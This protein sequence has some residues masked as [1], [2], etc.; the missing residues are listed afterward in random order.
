MCF[1]FVLLG[2]FIYVFSQATTNQT[3]KVHVALVDHDQTFETQTLAN[4]LQNEEALQDAIEITPYS[5][6]KANK[7]FQSNQVVALIEIPEGFTSDLRSGVNTP[8]TV[9]TNEDNPLSANMVKLLLDSGAQ[10]ISAAQSAINTVYD[11]YIQDL[12]E[13]DNPNELLQQFIVQYTLFALDRN[14]LFETEMIE[15]GSAL[16]W[17]QHGMIA[18]ILTSCMLSAIFFQMF[19]QKDEDQG[20]RHRLRTFHCTSFTWFWS[21]FLLYVILLFL[22]LVSIS[23]LLYGLMKMDWLLEFKTFGTWLAISLLFAII[24]S[25]LDWFIAN[26]TSRT[27]LFIIVISLLYFMSGIWLPL[28][29]LPAWVE[30]LS[31][32]SP[33]YQIYEGIEISI[34]SEEIPFQNWIT[35]GF[36][37]GIL[38]LFTLFKVW[39]K[40]RK[41][42]YLS[43]T[44]S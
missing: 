19:T 27:G 25:L 11:L 42:G 4:Q 18:F 13:Q 28:V 16:G 23:L 44:S 41:D 43:L 36:M 24:L 22:N 39:R 5:E 7:A 20:I 14:E 40:E 34:L 26:Q 35:L 29:Y 12:V 32:F 21:Q 1:P 38:M 10:Y 31:V 9:T 15:S 33:F 3:E 37:I 2:S 30:S 8:I 17:K 6:P